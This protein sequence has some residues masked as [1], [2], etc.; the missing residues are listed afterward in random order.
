[1]AD[2]RCPDSRTASGT[3]RDPDRALGRHRGR[4]PDR[5]SDKLFVGVHIDGVSVPLPVG[6]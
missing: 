5:R 1:M 4:I 3:S 2:S 6:G